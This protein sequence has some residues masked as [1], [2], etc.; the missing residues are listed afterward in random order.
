MSGDLC[1]IA[2]LRELSIAFPP[3]LTDM[4]RFERMHD[5]LL[6]HATS[7]PPAQRRDRF[8]L[9]YIIFRARDEYGKFLH[10]ENFAPEVGRASCDSRLGEENRRGRPR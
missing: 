7:A 10:F 4:L 5:R 9:T 3:E 8:R 6:D 1:G 2:P